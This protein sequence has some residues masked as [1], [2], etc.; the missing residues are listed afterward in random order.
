VLGD[1]A[2]FAA[3]QVLLVLLAVL[4]PFA[5]GGGQ[6]SRVRECEENET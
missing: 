6:K 3:E 4:V 1:E 2:A 5:Y